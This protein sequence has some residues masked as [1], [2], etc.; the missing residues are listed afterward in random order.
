MTR[1]VLVCVC[2]CACVPVR[3]VSAELLDKFKKKKRSVR[4]RL[5][6]WDERS[7]ISMHL[8]SRDTFYDM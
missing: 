5:S 2:M 6:H 8:L 4:V 3:V 1:C 7:Y